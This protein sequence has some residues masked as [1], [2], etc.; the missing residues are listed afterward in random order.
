MNILDKKRLEK[1]LMQVTAARY[2][3]EIRIEEMNMQIAELE[4]HI[5]IQ[6]DREEELKLKINN[7]GN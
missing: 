6:L 7:K 2:D 1:E 4:K 3:M 5:K